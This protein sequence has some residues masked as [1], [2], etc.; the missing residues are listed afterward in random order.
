MCVGDEYS[1]ISDHGL[2]RLLQRNDHRAFTELYHRYFTVLY[3]FTLYYLRDEEACRDAMQ[4][5]FMNLWEQ[6]QRIT[7]TSSVRSYLY[8]SAKNY[9]L[10]QIRAHKVRLQHGLSEQTKEKPEHTPSA[11]DFYERKELN[12]LI[13]LA[14]KN[15]GH[16]KKQ[17]IVEMRLQGMSNKD[18]A[19]QLG[20]P[21]NTVRTYYAQSLR[22]LRDY[23]GKLLVILA[24]I[25]HN[26]HQ[27]I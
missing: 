18:V 2:F 21:E 7:I 25:S 19:D 13:A 17:R 22:A 23:L 20:I 14:I 1:A 4:H 10:N 9:V 12:R 24:A 3:S 11:E 27:L 6:R 15:L 8:T 26:I 16:E 5:I